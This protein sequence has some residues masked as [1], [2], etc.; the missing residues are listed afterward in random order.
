MTI[1]KHLFVM[2]SKDLIIRRESTAGGAFSEI[3]KYVIHQGGVVFGAA[4]DKKMRVTHQ[5]VE[6]VA[7]L[8]RFRGSKYVQSQPGEAFVQVKSFLEQG[9]MVCFSGTP[10]QVSGLKSFLGKEYEG[11]ILV[12]VIC[13]ATPS[14]I[15]W[16]DYYVEITKNSPA[17]IK[18]VRFR[19]KFY[20]Y[21]FS[22][23]SLYTDDPKK[24]YHKGV[25]SDP[26]LRSFFSGS[27]IRPSCSKCAFKGIDKVAD[28]TLWDCFDICKYSREMDDD[29]GTTG[30]LVHSEKG[31]Q[32]L[33][34]ISDVVICKELPVKDGMGKSQLY[35]SAA[36]SP[37]R[38]AFMATYAEKG[39]KAAMEQFYPETI[40]TKLKWIGRVILTKT[41]LYTGIKR[42]NIIVK[43]KRK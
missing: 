35:Q 30:V 10:C 21:K 7:E 8:S 34:K 6:D 33:E 2:Q 40:K 9:R 17:A 26:W 41:G 31:M 4:F 25:E 29:K 14:P 22:T 24:D 20:G 23:F 5:Y 38:T 15:L 36:V 3:A 13:R 39:V 12:D 18:K 11:L 28:F 37:K 32:L 27:N 43:A 16:Q 1:P 42:L 19:D